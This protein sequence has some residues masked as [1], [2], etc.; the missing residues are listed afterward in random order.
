MKLAVIGTV[1]G[2]LGAVGAGYALARTLFQVKP[3][4][5]AI[6]TGVP[7]LL[8]TVALLASYIPARRATRIDPIVAAKAGVSWPK[9]S[10]GMIGGSI[11]HTIVL[12]QSSAAVW[13]CPV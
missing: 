13:R 10:F 6:M 11:L 8:L 1:L 2:L 3:T 12:V 7:L 5:I 9:V 4:D